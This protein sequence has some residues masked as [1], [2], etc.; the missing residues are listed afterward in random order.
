VLI[1][2]SGGNDVAKNN[3]MKAFR[4][5][6]DFAKNSSHTNVTL[7]RVPHRH[8]LMSSSCVNEEVRAFNQKLMKIRKIF[9]HVSIME[10][11]PN[12]EYYTKHGHHLNILGKAK[13][14]KQLSIQLLS[15]LQWKKDISIS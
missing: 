15:V 9:G 6:V 1:L 13:V 11:D 3:T 10:L 5:L 14:S 4:C 7:T 2:W 8:D 12:R